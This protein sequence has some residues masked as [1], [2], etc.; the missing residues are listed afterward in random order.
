MSAQ[1]PMI[2]SK[3]AKARLMWAWFEAHEN[4][5]MPEG[6]REVE[7]L[8]EVI[9]AEAR[10]AALDGGVWIVLREEQ[11]MAVWESEQDARDDWLRRTDHGRRPD[12]EHKYSIEHWSIGRAA[13]DALREGADD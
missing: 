1:T 7:A 11:P 10:A 9:E 2:D 3:G 6:R 5:P 12:L 8:F 4:Q 13:I